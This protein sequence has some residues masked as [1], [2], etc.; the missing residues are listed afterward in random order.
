[1]TSGEFVMRR[2]R[3]HETTICQCRFGGGDL[4]ATFGADRM[5]RIWSLKRIF[6]EAECKPTGTDNLKELLRFNSEFEDL[7][8]DDVV[9]E[10][11]IPDPRQSCL[12]R[13]YEGHQRW[14][15]DGAFS[16]DEAYLFSVSSDC[17]AR[18]WDLAVDPAERSPKY[19]LRR[20]PR[21]A[22]L[23]PESPRDLAL[24]RETV[25]VYAGHKRA[26]IACALED[27]LFP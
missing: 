6:E 17:T 27:S 11:V 10:G 19:E 1:M 3:A 8:G 15:W 21:S 25:C 14:V 23:E 18:L 7:A 9:D 13:Q 24:G 22:V 4:V 16:A 20:E 2:F 26:I 5:I 12:H